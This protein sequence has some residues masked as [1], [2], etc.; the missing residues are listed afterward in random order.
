MESP[1]LAARAVVLAALLAASSY[2]AAAAAAPAAPSP[3]PTPAPDLC[4]SGL[5]ALVSRPTQTTSPCSVAPGHVMIETG[6][7]TQTVDG[8]ANR[9][10]FQTA[11]NAT[12]RVGTRIPTLEF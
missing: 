9:Y 3:S 11:P 6:Y 4:S 1:H 12:I 7:Q 2:A 10:T 8:G 5:S